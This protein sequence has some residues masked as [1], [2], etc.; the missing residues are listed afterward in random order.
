MSNNSFW[1]PKSTSGK[2]I[3]N[4][5][6]I[7][8]DQLTLS[9]DI[10]PSIN[11]Q[12]NIGSSTSYINTLYVNNVVGWGGG[13]GGS[14]TATE[15]INIASD[16]ISLQID[17]TK[18]D[19]ASN[20]LSVK[21]SYVRGLF[22]ST[23]EAITYNDANGQSTFNYD[24]TKLEIASNQITLIDSYITSLTTASEPIEVTLTSGK[25]NLS[26]KL[27]S[28][29]LTTATI[30][31]ALTFSDAFVLSQDAIDTDLAANSAAIVAE[32]VRAEGA[33]LA[34][35]T[36][37]AANL[38]SIAVINGEISGFATSFTT[39]VINSTLASGVNLNLTNNSS[40]N[41]TIFQENLAPNLNTGNCCETVMG[42]SLSNY[43]C[44]ATQFNY[45]GNGSTS[46]TLGFGFAGANNLMTLD[47]NGNIIASGSVSSGQMLSTINNIYNANIVAINNTTSNVKTC[48]YLA[49]NLANGNRVEFHIGVSEATNNVGVIQFNYIGSNT[50]ANSLGF[51]FYGNNNLMS[52]DGTG[53]FSAPTVSTS[54]LTV[55]NSSSTSIS[56]T[57]ILTPSLSTGNQSTIVH[58][59]DNYNPRN[60]ALIDFN[61]SGSSSPSNTL[62]FGFT[63]YPGM[64]TIDAGGGFN[65][66]QN[67]INCNYSINANQQVN[68]STSM[69]VGTDIAVAGQVL[70]K[71]LQ[72]NV[73]CIQQKNAQS[74]LSTAF[75]MILFDGSTF[76]TSGTSGITYSAGT[77]TNSNS[78][79]ISIHINYNISFGGNAGATYKYAQVACGGNYYGYSMFPLGS[80]Y[81]TS[82]TGGVILTLAPSATFYIGVG[83]GV[84]EST[85]SNGTTT[86]Y[87][88]SCSMTVF[89]HV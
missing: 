78:Y 18:L 46:N 89:Q 40:A 55:S 37:V 23:T 88:T 82:V 3:I 14:Y 72:G 22:S 73:Y 42:V 45:V 67:S 74:L 13:G 81:V 33:E 17:T 48:E 26:L 1:L 10:I 77:F 68:A 79:T 36:G 51:G 87:S 24:S 63:D 57:Q 9:T 84:T 38:A 5:V 70:S 30:G 25:N 43:N 34:L 47:G 11:N 61:Y 71:R 53:L 54:A 4:N 75:N 41:F 62:E 32:N 21:D 44:I 56:S 7:Q 80:T 64:V 12:Y 59:V 49:P 60:A 76:N 65:V 39:G 35:S 6:E 58:G 28:A 69:S 52:I 85:N 50:T 31:S 19:L 15:P 86:D 20:E 83:V 8:G 66:T 2:S 27:D 29:Y 16:V